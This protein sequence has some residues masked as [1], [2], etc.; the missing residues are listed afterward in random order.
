MGE[1]ITRRLLI[2]I[3]CGGLIAG[4]ISAIPQAQA[5]GHMV[6]ASVSWVGPRCID[7][8]QPVAGNYYQLMTGPI[9]SGSRELTVSTGANSGQWVGLDPIIGSASSVA[10]FLIIDGR[11]DYSDYA[12][13]GDG[14]DC[15]CL[16]ILL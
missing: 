1:R 11:I 3:A 2:L 7:A 10:C 15:N 13:A 4:G 9:C 14:H 5:G 6:T 8:T 16:R 12:A